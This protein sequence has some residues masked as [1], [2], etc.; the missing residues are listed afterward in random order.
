[1]IVCIAI[2]WTNCIEKLYAVSGKHVVLAL[3]QYLSLFSGYLVIAVNLFK[4]ENK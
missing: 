4:F 3:P 1:M 2:N